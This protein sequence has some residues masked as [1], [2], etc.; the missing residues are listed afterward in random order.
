[1]F[2]FFLRVGMSLTSLAITP[3]SCGGCIASSHDAN[4]FASANC[5]EKQH[6][7]GVSSPDPTGPL[8]AAHFVSR[9]SE[10]AGVEVRIL[11]LGGLDTV[12][13]D[14]VRIPI[15]TVPIEQGHLPFM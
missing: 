2:I 13:A 14:V 7:P 4:L 15:F 3:F 11:G 1:M 9:C 10:A 12:F 6:A 5:D 8:F